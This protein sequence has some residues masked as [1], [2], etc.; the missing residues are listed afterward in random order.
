[1][2]ANGTVALDDLAEVRAYVLGWG[3]LKARVAELEAKIE[4]CGLD[5]GDK[6]AFDRL[7]EECVEAAGLPPLG[8]GIEYGGEGLRKGI[9]ALVAVVTAA[10]RYVAARRRAVRTESDQ[11]DR[12]DA[13]DA[14][15]KAVGPLKSTDGGES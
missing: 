3:D 5:H 9:R 13:F 8:E 7:L 1:M 14:L 15:A 6:C 11:T 12:V 2:M 4:G 10:R